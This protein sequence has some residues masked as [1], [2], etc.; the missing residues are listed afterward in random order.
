M[1]QMWPDLFQKAK[2]GGLDAIETYVFWNAHEPRRR[3]YNFEGNLDL[4]RFLEEIQRA[5]LYSII[6]I[7]PYVCAEWNYGGL[8]VWLH[9]VPGM[10][11]RSNNQQFKDEMQIFTTLIVDMIKKKRLLAPQGGPIILTQIENEYGDIE[12]NYGESAKLYVNWCAKMAQSQ[13][14]G[15]P[16]I[17]CQQDDAPLPMINTH[18]GFYFNNFVPNNPNSPKIWTENW[19]GWFQSWGM[20]KLHRPVEDLAFSAAIFFQQTGSLLNYYMYHGGTNL[21]RSSGGPYVTTS[22]DYDAP[23]DEYGNLRQPKWGH[24]KNLHEAIKSIEKVLLYGQSKTVDLGNGTLSTK[25]S[26]NETIP[27]SGCFLVNTNSSADANITFEG[28]VYF[29][30]GKSVS[31]LLD[32]KQEIYNTAKVDYHNSYIE[33]IPNEAEDEPLQ[34]NWS[35]R[36]EIDKGI[37]DVIIT[38]SNNTKKGILEQIMVTADASDYL[39]YITNVDHNGTENE[40]KLQVDMNGHILHVFINEE[41]VGSYYPDRKK[42]PYVFEQTVVIKPGINQIALLGVTVGLKNDGAFFDTNLTGISRAGVLL[43]GNDNSTKNLSSNKWSYKIGLN[44]EEKEF[45]SSSG[46]D[47]DGKSWQSN[48]IPVKKPFTWYTTIFKAPL[49]GEPVVIDLEGMGKGEAWVNGKSIGRFWSDFIASESYGAQCGECDYLNDLKTDYIPCQT[50]C[51]LPSQRWYHVPRYF[52]KPGEPNVLTLFEEKGGNPTAISFKTAKVGR[53]CGVVPEGRTLSLSCQGTRRI[54]KIEFTSFGDS[55]GKCGLVNTEEF[56]EATCESSGA[57][58]AVK[59]ACIGMS[60]CSI[61][62]TEMRLGWS[63]C[64][65]M[66]KKL[67]VQAVCS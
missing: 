2:D 11:M 44:G 33:M 53:L 18:N 65:S 62:A 15:I 30:P 25:Y 57:M 6:R 29:L 55:E 19:S 13:N 12:A 37:G 41:L 47:Q 50:G 43:I 16:W 17:M 48:E 42:W 54:T 35:W 28:S 46:I 7:G 1:I 39:W 14:T 32:C 56:K 58:S 40:M 63:S 21:G 67:A 9:K 59:K 5:G 20:G 10:V 60:T 38:A 24:L 23:L 36:S 51:G 8:P 27:A 26:A 61:E 52:L 22:Y 45:Y 34:L 31:I 3:Q 64:G 49:G 66:P 4:I